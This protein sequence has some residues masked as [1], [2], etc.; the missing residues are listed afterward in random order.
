MHH[1]RQFPELSLAGSMQ[2]APLP[3]VRPQCPPSLSAGAAY[4]NRP[5]SL[6]AGAARRCGEDR[7]GLDNLAGGT[8][9][10][11]SL[12]APSDSTA[13][14]LLWRDTRGTEAARHEGRLGRRTTNR[15]GRPRCSCRSCSA[16][17]TSQRRRH[18]EDNGAELFPDMAALYSCMHLFLP[19]CKAQHLLL[20]NFIMFLPAQL[21]SLFRS[22]WIAVQ[23]SGMLD[24]PP[25]FLSLVHLLTADTIHLSRLLMK[26]WNK[27]GPSTDPWGTLLNTGFQLDSVPLIRT[28]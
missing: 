6:L 22:C 28:L 1:T 11:S 24:T 27:A 17:V 7:L 3:A 18:V 23:S 5:R 25:C 20:L 13:S 14:N 16:S 12:T 19:R 21:S 26:I 9:I 15:T 10:A 2:A 4:G 8:P